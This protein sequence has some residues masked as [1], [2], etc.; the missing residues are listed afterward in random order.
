MPVAAAVL[1]RLALLHGLPTE[2]LDTLGKYMSL[3]TFARRAVVLNRGEEGHGL[4]FL[5]EGRLQG[6]DFT[7]DGREVG[8]YF[9]AAGDYFGELSVV[10]DGPAPEFV[11]ALGRAQVAFLPREAARGLVLSTPS[12]AEKVMKR[13]S[14]RVRSA[15]AQRTLLSLPNPVQRLTV[16]ADMLEKNLGLEHIRA[17][18]EYL[19]AEGAYQLSL[20]HTEEDN[21]LVT[22]FPWLV[23][24][25]ITPNP[26]EALVHL[27]MHLTLLGIVCEEVVDRRH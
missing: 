3:H 11:M 2:A 6:V 8:L 21:A 7:L 20:H 16:I 26:E 24:P 14:A 9:V 25:D 12:I 17:R 5:L 19:P 18:V 27:K 22:R 23:T 13:L 4:G 1:Q 15:S 10:D